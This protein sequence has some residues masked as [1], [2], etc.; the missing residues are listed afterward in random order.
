MAKKEFLISPAGRA[1]FPKLK[2]PDTKFKKEGEYVVKLILTAAEAEPLLEN[3][4]RI[5]QEAFDEEFEKQR[6]DKPKMSPAKIKE[7]IPFADLPVKPYEDPETGEDTGDYQVTFKMAASGISKKTG[8]PWTRRPALFDAKSKPIDPNKV[9]IWSGSVLKVSYTADPFC[10]AI[11]AGVSLRM[12]AVQI[13]E[14][15]SGGQRDAAGYG[16]GA[17]EGG[18]AYEEDYSDDSGSPFPSDEEMAANSDPTPGVS[19]F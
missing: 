10:T 16:F 15:R 19:D 3:C 12:E 7:K 2:E 13:I 6:A 18:Y 11:G 5:Q 4:Q 9:D 8:K 17:E 14:L 1:L